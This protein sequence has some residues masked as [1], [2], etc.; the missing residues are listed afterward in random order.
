MDFC[1]AVDN[2]HLSDGRMTP[3]ITKVIGQDQGGT[4]NGREDTMPGQMDRAALQLPRDIPE[5]AYDHLST[6]RKF[7]DRR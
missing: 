4:P 3:V 7:S 6:Y 2:Q 5:Q 1:S